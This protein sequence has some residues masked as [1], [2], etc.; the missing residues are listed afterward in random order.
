MSAVATF[1]TV[2]P[3]FA[4]LRRLTEI[5]RALTYTTSLEQVTRLTVER[6]TELVDATAAVLMLAD[7]EG[8][9]HVRAAHGVTEDRITRF[10]APLTAEVINR[11]PGLLAVDRQDLEVREEVATRAHEVA[12]LQ[13]LVIAP[14]VVDREDVGVTRQRHWGNPLPNLSPG[15]IDGGF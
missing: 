3:E 14:L 13:V 1:A 11:H 8:L 4:Q 2:D 7:S 15:I 10:Q 9:L 5:S 12:H 6:G